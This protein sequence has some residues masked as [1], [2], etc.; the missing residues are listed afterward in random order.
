M[1]L[2]EALP[3]T[4]LSK[5]MLALAETNSEHADELRARAEELDRAWAEIV[6]R[7]SQ[8]DPKMLIATWSRARKL[9]CSLSGEDPLE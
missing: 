5:K 4:E 9:Y 1:P 6:G 8:E 7:T 2:E 3:K